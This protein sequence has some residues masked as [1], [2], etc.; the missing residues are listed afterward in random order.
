[1]KVC[2]N[3]FNISVYFILECIKTILLQRSVTNTI[4]IY[5]TLLWEWYIV[6]VFLTTNN[7]MQ[8]LNYS[9]RVQ[10]FDH[11]T[12]QWCIHTKST[13]WMAYV[14]QSFSN[15]F[16]VRNISYIYCTCS[17]FSHISSIDHFLQIR[18]IF[19]NIFASKNIF[20]TESI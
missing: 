1:M 12:L 10:I 3:F 18:K 14:K 8:T 2:A 7:A 9:I 16:V 19:R 6:E 11:K 17:W 5:I 4:Y 15:F 13:S 20:L